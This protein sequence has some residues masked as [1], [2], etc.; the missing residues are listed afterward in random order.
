M[1]LSGHDL[2]SEHFMLRREDGVLELSLVHPLEEGSIKQVQLG[3]MDV[4]EAD[5]I[6]VTYDFVRDGWVIKQPTIDEWA[7]DDL[8]RDEGWREVAFVKSWNRP[9]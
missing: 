1:T 3:L 6:R 7:Q 8:V 5:D 9:D 4:H 2:V